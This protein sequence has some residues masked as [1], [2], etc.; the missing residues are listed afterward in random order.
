MGAGEAG[1]QAEGGRM[2][3][4]PF[5]ARLWT[6]AGT[7]KNSQLEPKNQQNLLQSKDTC[8]AKD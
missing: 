1:G 5:A 3:S 8:R 4:R 7:M 2:I 6:G